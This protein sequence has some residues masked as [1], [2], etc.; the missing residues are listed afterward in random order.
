MNNKHSYK[1]RRYEIVPYNPDWTNKFE[2]YKSK[3]KKIFPNFQIEHIGS[4][5]VLGMAGKPCIDILVIVDDI[6]TVEGNV[7]E[8]EQAVFEY[9]GQF[10]ME[11]S[12]LFRVMKDNSLLANIH[13]F[14]IGHPHNDEMINLRNYLRAHPQEAENYS[15]IK[16]N[17][18]SK[19]ENDYASYR[20]YKDEYMNELKKRVQKK[21]A[22][23]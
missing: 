11:N 13:F 2:E 20:K 17:L 19:Y 18:Y 5:S 15:K 3:I 4:T 22:T 21:I 10:V 9:A 23:S 1:D 8:M 6:K 16:E 7:R 12:R 14:P